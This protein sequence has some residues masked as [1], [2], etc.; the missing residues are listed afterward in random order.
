MVLSI[1][2]LQEYQM[3]SQWNL[4]EFNKAKLQGVIKKKSCRTVRRL[5]KCIT[6]KLARQIQKNLKNITC[7]SCYES[8]KAGKCHTL[9]VSLI[10]PLTMTRMIQVL[11]CYAVQDISED[12]SSN[13]TKDRHSLTWH[14]FF[15]RQVLENLFFRESYLCSGLIL[16]VI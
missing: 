15:P 13:L 3:D 10:I 6:K 7:S 2:N 16:Y 5:P 9:L 1:Q 12:Q 11:L 4:H 14:H 8:N